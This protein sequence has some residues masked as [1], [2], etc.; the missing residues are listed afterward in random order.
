MVFVKSV[1]TR[2]EKILQERLAG[3]AFLEDSRITSGP[4]CGSHNCTLSQRRPQY[5]PTK[6]LMSARKRPRKSPRAFRLGAEVT[7]PDIR[8]SGGSDVLLLPPPAATYL[9]R[10]ISNYR[11]RPRKA[12]SEN[13]QFRGKLGK[14]RT[15]VRRELKYRGSAFKRAL[16]NLILPSPSFFPL[17]F[18]FVPPRR[19]LLTRVF[20]ICD[21]RRRTTL[22]PP[23]YG[24]EVHAILPRVASFSANLGV[25]LAAGLHATFLKKKGKFSLMTFKER[26]LVPP[27]RRPIFF[28]SLPLQFWSVF[29]LN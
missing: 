5:R 14:R 7:E 26:R 21:H 6:E 20:C 15:K 3:S 22:F 4:H 27:I 25:A 18:I 1:D 17:L 24:N 8:K 29:T 28:I 19:Q 23:N 10:F 13:S 11:V 2:E 12:Y 16:I 9:A